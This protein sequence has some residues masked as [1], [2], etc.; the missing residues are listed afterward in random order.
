[1]SELI[2]PSRALMN[3]LFLIIIVLLGFTMQFGN[4]KINIYAHLG[5]FFTGLVLLPILQKPVQEADG[6]LCV[7]KYWLYV[8]AVLLLIFF[9]SALIDIFAL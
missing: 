2:G 6:A 7:Y 9:A 3:I 1:M 8:C 4:E 5:G